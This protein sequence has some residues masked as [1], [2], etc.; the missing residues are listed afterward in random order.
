MTL[1]RGCSRVVVGAGLPALRAPDCPGH[2]SALGAGTSHADEHGS[3]SAARR[4]SPRLGAPATTLYGLGSGRV[5]PWVVPR[6]LPTEVLIPR[7]S[8]STGRAADF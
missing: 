1:A 7:A 2:G 4:S 5:V 8:S 6:D 3:A